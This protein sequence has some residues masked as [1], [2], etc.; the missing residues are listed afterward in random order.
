MV[1]PGLRGEEN[2][3]WVLSGYKVPVWSDEHFW[4]ETVVI[5]ELCERTKCY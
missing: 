2:E 4:N 1:V 5:A 3:Q